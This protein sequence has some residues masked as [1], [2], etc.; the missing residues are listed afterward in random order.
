[1]S[2]PVK[3]ESLMRSPC[4]V[5]ILGFI[6]GLVETRGSVRDKDLIQGCLPPA[7]IAAKYKANIPVHRT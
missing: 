2:I 4:H 6:L 3:R 1:M 5:R 7:A